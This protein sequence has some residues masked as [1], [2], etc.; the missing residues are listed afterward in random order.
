MTPPPGNRGHRAG[1]THARGRSRVDSGPITTGSAR[2][3]VADQADE[4]PPVQ[5]WYRQLLWPVLA[6]AAATAAMLVSGVPP[7]RAVV[8]AIAAGVA[9]WAV[10]M[11]MTA[12]AP[13]RLYDVPSELHQLRT[14]WEVGGLLGAGQSAEIFAKQLRPRLWELTRELLQRRGIDPESDRAAAL[15]GRREYALLTGAD[16]DPKRTT[17]S[18]SVLCRTIARLAVEP[19]AGT[20][21][22]IRNPALAGLAGPNRRPDRRRA[23]TPRSEGP[24]R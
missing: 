2:E 24:S 5:R 4:G 1:V 21:P 19:A 18:V 17:S 15:V 22:V 20:E 14:R 23:A 16:T 13:G 8:I 9:L 11:S 6:A 3:P 7:W 10:L 12:A